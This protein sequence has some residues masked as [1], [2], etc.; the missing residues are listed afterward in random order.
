MSSSEAKKALLEKVA[1]DGVKFISLQFTDIVGTIKSVTITP[2]RLVKPANGD[3][4]I[5]SGNSTMRSTPFAEAND[6]LPMAVEIENVLS[7][8]MPE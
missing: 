8:D 5:T 2:G 1:V 4:E 7:G 6:T 3:A